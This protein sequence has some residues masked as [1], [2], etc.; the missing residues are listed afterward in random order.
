MFC[1]AEDVGM[2]VNC[3]TFLGL[4]NKHTKADRRA[5]HSNEIRLN[6][7]T[8]LFML[9]DMIYLKDVSEVLCLGF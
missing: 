7:G 5:S 2:L 6:H 9:D 4:G 3:C 1:C 8:R